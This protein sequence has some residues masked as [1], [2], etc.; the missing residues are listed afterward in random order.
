MAAI[1]R[2]GWKEKALT[3]SASSNYYALASH[4]EV[5]NLLKEQKVSLPEAA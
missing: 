3:V 1:G 2:Y 4:Q 5:E